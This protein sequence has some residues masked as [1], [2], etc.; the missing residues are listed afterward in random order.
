MVVVKERKPTV[1]SIY[2]WFNNH[3][4]VQ[5][6]S[7]VVETSA[8]VPL[9]SMRLFAAAKW[10]AWLVSKESPCLSPNYTKSATN[11]TAPP[12]VVSLQ[13][14]HKKYSGY[15]NPLFPILY[16]DQTNVQECLHMVK[17]GVQLV[18]SEPPGA[19]GYYSGNFKL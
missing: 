4:N 13:T 11:L 9:I 15:K 2:Y 12:A 6:S 3:L 7:P 5:G 10:S 8:G 1:I 17:W 16:E 19:P 14:A 18:A